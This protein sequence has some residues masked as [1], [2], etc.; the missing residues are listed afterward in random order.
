MRPIALVAKPR[1]AR[2]LL[3]RHLREEGMTIS[4]DL[5]RA[6]GV[7]QEYAR[8]AMTRTCHALPAA[9]IEAAIVLLRLDEFDANELRRAAAWDAGYRWDA[10]LTL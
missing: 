2:E 9:R 10:S 4:G 8:K 6:W 3:R 7:R 5:A 1:T